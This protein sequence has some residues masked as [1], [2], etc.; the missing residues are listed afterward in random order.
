[1]NWNNDF[2]TLLYQEIFM[3]RSQ[4]DIDF[5]VDSII[6][7]SHKTTGS[8]VDFCCGVG[9]ILEG[10][11]RK[12][13]ETYGVDFS[14]EYVQKANIQY[15]QKNVIYGDALLINFN[16]TFDLSI[17]WFSSFGYFDDNKNQQLLN[18]IFNHT[19]IGGAFVLEIYNSYDIIKNF[20]PILVYEKIYK[21]EPIK[22]T[23]HSNYLIYERKLIQNW[24]F[25]YKKESFQY[26]T[27]NKIYFVDEIINKMKIAGFKKIKVFNRNKVD[28]ILTEA[29]LDSVR[30]I[31]KGEK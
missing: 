19:K 18:N 13:F 9:D 25:T 6:N 5:D 20:K 15:N 4:K 2:F 21:N 8:I 28:S 31:F 3:N 12:G 27:E 7:I 11:E 23:R 30:L 1:M 10:F 16:K 14:N 22:I 24:T 26:K 29:T 17:N